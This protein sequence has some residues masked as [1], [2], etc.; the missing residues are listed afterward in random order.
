MTEEIL[1]A[2]TMRLES[3]AKEQLAIIKDMYHRPAETGTVD[4]IAQQA[5]NLEQLEGAALTLQQ[6]APWL[7]KQTEAEAESNAPV[8]PTEV[9]VEEEESDHEKLMKQSS[10]YRESVKKREKLKGSKEK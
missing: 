4:K 8:E 3:K 9:E 5:L 7:A 6:Y 1:E 2:A 10:T